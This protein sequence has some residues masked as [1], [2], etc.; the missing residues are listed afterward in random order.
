MV[1]LRNCDKQIAVR[2]VELDAGEARR[3]R[4]P[5]CADEASDRGLDLLLVGER[6]ERD[7]IGDFGAASQVPLRK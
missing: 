7:A 3:L 2:G 4:T 1:G 5:R 6:C